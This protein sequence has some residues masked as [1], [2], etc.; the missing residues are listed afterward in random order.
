MIVKIDLEKAHDHV[1]W[2]LLEQVLKV[3]GF[4]ENLRSLIMY[5]I[6]SASLLCVGIDGH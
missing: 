5:C 6:S 4:D 2:E 3:S 1:D